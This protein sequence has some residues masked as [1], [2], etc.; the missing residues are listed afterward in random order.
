MSV[1]R[2]EANQ[3]VLNETREVQ[4]NTKDALS[5]IKATTAETEDIADQTLE[6]LREQGQQIDDITADI[7]AVSGKLDEAQKLQ[8]TFDNWS[9]GIFGF[10][11]R[12]AEKAASA[13]IALRQ[14][15]ELMS[16]KEVFEQQKYDTF[17]SSWKPYNMV[18][19]SNPTLEAP[20]L[21]VPS[22]Q[23]SIPNS[24]WK[25]DSSLTGVDG[26]GWTYAYD[27][28]KLNK[29]FDGCTSFCMIF[30]YRNSLCVVLL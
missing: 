26:D 9:G 18:M 3:R 30:W 19:C 24:S 4:A 20:E 7:D 2:K 25:V 22:V 13:E 11:K 17:R 23:D 1:N 5:R 27:F 28:N 8:N 10:G 21:F 14:Q 16:I 12:K 29:V 6:Q 15:E